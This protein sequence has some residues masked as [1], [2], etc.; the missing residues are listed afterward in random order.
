MAVD[1]ELQGCIKFNGLIV[2]LKINKYSSSFIFLDI[3]Q[4]VA[5][6]IY[7]SRS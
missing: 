3:I 4:V 1:F 6:H 7:V 2:F 5:V